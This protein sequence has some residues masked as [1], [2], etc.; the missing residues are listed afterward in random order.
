MK[1][2]ELISLWRADVDDTVE[3]YKW[4]DKEAIEY[5]NDAELEAAR[6]ARLLVDSTTVQF[7][8]LSATVANNGLV[9]LDPKVLFV[10]RAR[11]DGYRPMHRMNMQ[12]MDANNPY[13]QDG[14]ANRPSVFIPDYETGKLQ[15]WPFPDATYSIQLTVVRDPA[16]EMNDVEDTPEI[17]ARYHRSLRHWMSHRAY[18]KQDAEANDPKKAAESLALFEQEFGKKSSAVDEAWIQREQYESDGTF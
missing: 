3:P 16:A 12:D 8:T 10:R 1:L 13:W 5:A 2:R 7:C 4:T 9:T 15:F 14:A 6:R 18:N 11:I 17:N